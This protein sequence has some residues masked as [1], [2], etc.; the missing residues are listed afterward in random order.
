MYRFIKKNELEAIINH[1]KGDVLELGSFYGATA[2]GIVSNDC[3]KSI[4]CVDRWEH[5]PCHE[6]SALS[7]FIENLNQ[8]YNNIKLLK[9]NT[10]EAYPYILSNRYDMVFID[11]S[12]NNA[13]AMRDLCVCTLVSDIVLVHDY[14]CQTPDGNAKDVVDWFTKYNPKWDIVNVVERLAILKK[15]S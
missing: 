11:A 12:H 1:A 8:Y 9:M 10:R 6:V 3:V 7:A 15:T 2:L 14:G 5:N 13:E 4:T